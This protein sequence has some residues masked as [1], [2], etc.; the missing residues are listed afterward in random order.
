MSTQRRFLSASKSGEKKRACKP[1]P[2]PAE[3]PVGAM[4]GFTDQEDDDGCS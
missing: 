2:K 4:P 1:P 3:R